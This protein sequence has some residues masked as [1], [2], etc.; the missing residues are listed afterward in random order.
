M[1]V[2][3]EDSLIWVDGEL[4]PWPEAT[5]HA[6][7]HVVHY[8]SSIFEGV[9][10]YHTARGPAILRLREHLRRLYAS[11]KMYKIKIP[12]ELETL[13]DA[14]QTVIRENKYEE[15]YIRPVVFRG[16]GAIGIDPTNAPIQTVI[17]A[18][19]WGSYLGEEALKK[20]VDVCVSSWQ[21]LRPNT[22]PAM[23]KAGGQYLL[24][25]LV[26]MEAKQNGYAEGILLDANGF[27]SEGSGE[28]IFVIL[29]GK[30]YTTPVS[31]SILAG[32]TRNCAI[33]IL[34][35]LNVEVV[36]AVLPREFLY[37]ADE[38]FFTGTAAEVAPIRSVD[39]ID[40]GAGKPG[41]ITKSVQKRYFDLIT[42]RSEDVHNW[43]TFV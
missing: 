21:K 12:F 5:I 38:I 20:G 33:T 27:I 29:D 35:E 23:G 9:R 2:F 8:G 40:V 11:A 16:Y 34:K 7:S 17:G 19:P 36:E 28:N 6:M 25:Q 13:T 26:K 39:R 32:V 22:I 41:E 1:S 42:G 3:R 15:A 14:C 43:L 30:A 24:S 18:W 10:C 37:T 4:K 31:A